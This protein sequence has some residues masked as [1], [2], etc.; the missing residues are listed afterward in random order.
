[1]AASVSHLHLCAIC[2]QFID[3]LVNAYELASR[4]FVFQFTQKSSKL[5][6]ILR[7]AS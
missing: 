5:P 6:W 3:V 7:L 2:D 1:M 4:T